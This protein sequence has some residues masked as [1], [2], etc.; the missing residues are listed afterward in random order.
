MNFFSG[1]LLTAIQW[2]FTDSLRLL[3]IHIKSEHKIYYVNFGGI[4]S[5]LSIFSSSLILL[6]KDK[7]KL[8]LIVD[9]VE[10]CYKPRV[11][12]AVLLFHL[13]WSRPL[14]GGPAAL[15][16]VALGCP[17]IMWN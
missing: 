11:A 9:L 12:N 6:F 5:A 3:L 7:I 10:V 17:T 4:I 15:E 1:A 14:L 16:T 8:E 2:I 13:A